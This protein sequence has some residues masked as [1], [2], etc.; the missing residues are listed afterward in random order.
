[1]KVLPALG[2]SSGWLALRFSSSSFIRPRIAAGS[3]GV[4]QNS[5]RST[6]AS[7]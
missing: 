1:L 6:T 5:A 2:N 7:G 4:R 3:P